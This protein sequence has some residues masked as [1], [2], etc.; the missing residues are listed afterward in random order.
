METRF[1][2]YRGAHGNWQNFGS[3]NASGQAGLYVMSSS[4]HRASLLDER[5]P[6]AFEAEECQKA[7]LPAAIPVSLQTISLP[8]N[9]KNIDL[10]ENAY[11][12]IGFFVRQTPRNLCTEYVQR[13]PADAQFASK[14]LL[15][16]LA[17][18]FAD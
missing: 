3:V 12:I 5:G 8:I 14:E 7:N 18:F 16:L 17:H 11:D 13:P 1:R 10:A 4:I 6:P 2:Q 15:N 9:G